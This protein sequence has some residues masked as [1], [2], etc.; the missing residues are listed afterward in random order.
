MDTKRR[1]KIMTF[2]QFIKSDMGKK[3]VQEAKVKQ[4]HQEG[5]QNAYHTNLSGLG[6]NPRPK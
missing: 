6:C 5:M 2:K 3:M 1:Y 4:E